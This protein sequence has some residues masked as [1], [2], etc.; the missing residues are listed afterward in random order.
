ML[1]HVLIVKVRTLCRNMLYQNA[2]AISAQ[3]TM[4][5]AQSSASS[6]LV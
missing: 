4:R 1:E 3:Q 6:G 5:Q 2:H